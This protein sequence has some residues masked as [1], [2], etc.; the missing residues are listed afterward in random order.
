MEPLGDNPAA[1]LFRRFTPRARTADERPLDRASV[2]ALDALFSESRHDFCSIVSTPVAALTSLTP[3][4]PD[5][6][7]LKACARL[8]GALA[9]TPL[10][11]WA[12]AI[13]IHWV[14]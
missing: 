6:A 5:N 12:R 10:K 13:Y 1:K 9:R 4:R 2:T 3:L 11:W 8:D 7:A 14:K